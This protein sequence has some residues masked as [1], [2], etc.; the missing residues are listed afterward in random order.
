MTAGSGSPDCSPA[1]RAD[2]A[3]ANETLHRIVWIG[4]SREA[5]VQPIGFD[6]NDE[7]NEDG[8]SRRSSAHAQDRGGSTRKP[9]LPQARS[10]IDTVSVTSRCSC[11][12]LIVTL[13]SDFA[14]AAGPGPWVIGMSFAFSAV[15]V[16]GM[17][18]T[19]NAI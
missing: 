2:E 15:M 5:E 10:A 7:R 3:A 8:D 18:A 6:R 19:R 1:A 13:S 17:D 12:T 11:A 9:P 4:A 14:K 16:A